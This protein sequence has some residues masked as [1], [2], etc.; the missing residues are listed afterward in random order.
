MKNLFAKKE[1]KTLKEKKHY[2]NWFIRYNEAIGKNYFSRGMCL[3]FVFICCSGGFVINIL[4][5]IYK[6]CKL[7]EIAFLM[8]V[9]LVLQLFSLVMAL[10]NLIK[11]KD[12]FFGPW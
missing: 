5:A 4:N 1:K 11:Y 6:S 3:A 10:V 12:W 7:E 2:N 8:F 9:V